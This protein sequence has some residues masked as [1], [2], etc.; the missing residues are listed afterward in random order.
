MF[1][2][3]HTLESLILWVA[4]KEMHRGH[5]LASLNFETF[6][7]ATTQSVRVGEGRRVVYI[8]TVASLSRCYNK[9]DGYVS[10]SYL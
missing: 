3:M 5:I 9:V 6:T 1:Y 4:R 10:P 7:G 2:E 8:S